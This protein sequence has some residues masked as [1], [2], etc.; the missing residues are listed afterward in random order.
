[1]TELKMDKNS[2]PTTIS[3]ALN[4]I[5]NQLLLECDSHY[6]L[7]CFDGSRLI[8]FRIDNI[9]YEMR[10]DGKNYLSLEVM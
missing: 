4:L 1:M 6:H 5:G 9:E 8:R 10:F 3:T 7:N 2:L